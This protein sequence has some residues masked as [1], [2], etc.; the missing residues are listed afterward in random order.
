MHKRKFNNPALLFAVFITDVRFL[1]GIAQSALY[2]ASFLR[3]NKYA[4]LISGLKIYEYEKNTTHYV[5][6]HLTDV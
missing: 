2:N 1:H 5:F 3:A 4:P 6:H